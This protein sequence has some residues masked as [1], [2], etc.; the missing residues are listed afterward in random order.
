VNLFKILCNKMGFDYYKFLKHSD[1]KPGLL[2]WTTRFPTW[3]VHVGF[4]VDKVA[5]R[6]VFSEL[7][8]FFLLVSFYQCSILIYV[9]NEQ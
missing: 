8:N 4:V 3:S 2:P 9:V 1:V 6:Q 5:V 7:F